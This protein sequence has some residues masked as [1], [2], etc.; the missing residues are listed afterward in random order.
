LR[1]QFGEGGGKGSLAVGLTE[2]E[3]VDLVRD[4]AEVGGTLAVS[5]TR[6]LLAG[7]SRGEEA[8]GQGKD[9]HGG[10]GKGKGPITAQAARSFRRATA[11]V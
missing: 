7:T 11:A 4:L 3:G 10:G 6:T 9:N 2:I 5:L 1:L 8:N